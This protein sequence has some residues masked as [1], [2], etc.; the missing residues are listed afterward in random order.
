MSGAGNAAAAVSLN[1]VKA[2]LRVETIA[3]DALIAGLLRTATN[4]CEQFT[5]Q[6][7]LA[8]ERTEQV[9]ADGCWH[10][11]AATPMKRL[12]TGVSIDAAGTE[13]PLPVEEIETQIDFCGDGWVR[14]APDTERVRARLT[15]EAGLAA[16]WNDLPEAVRQG[17]IRLVAHLYAH[18]DGADDAGPPAAIAALW[19]PWRR[20][21]LS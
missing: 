17:I 19:R 6:V 2:Y 4:L 1:E 18:R 20:M 9:P 10:R 11:I 7:A 5:G 14:V 13:T 16:D 3:D 12:V 21:R 8:S 15:I